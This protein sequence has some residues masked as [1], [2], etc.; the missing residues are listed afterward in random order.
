MSQQ[1]SLPYQ[2]LSSNFLR[3]LAETLRREIRFRKNTRVKTMSTKLHDVC[4][5]SFSGTNWHGLIPFQTSVRGRRVLMWQDRKR[6]DHEK[7]SNEKKVVSVCR[8]DFILVF[9][10]G[11]GLCH[12]GGWFRCS[13]MRCVFGSLFL[14]VQVFHCHICCLLT[15]VLGGNLQHAPPSDFTPP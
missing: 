12:E 2:R 3:Y 6:D 4:C 13:R 7:T 10:P 5:H 8:G 15:F 14:Q 9:D 1:R 11:V